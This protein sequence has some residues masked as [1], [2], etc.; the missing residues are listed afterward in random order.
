M[1][2]PVG[3]GMNDNE[4]GRN[5]APIMIANYVIIVKMTLNCVAPLVN[6]R[7]YGARLMQTRCFSRGEHSENGLYKQATPPGLPGC[8]ATGARAFT[9]TVVCSSL[10]L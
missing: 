4:I 3:L 6:T 1:A 10:C 9:S 2:P 7:S 5:Y 8:G